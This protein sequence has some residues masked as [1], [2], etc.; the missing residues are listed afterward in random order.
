M[1]S[2]VQAVASG[3]V[4]VVNE[5]NYPWLVKGSYADYIG[6]TGGYVLPNGTLLLSLWGNSF[7]SANTTLNWLVLNRTGDMAWL[8]L[9]YHAS[10]C[11]VSRE[12]YAD[13]AKYN[14]TR[15]PCTKFEFGV[16]QTLEM[17]VVTSEVYNGSQPAGILNFWAPPLISSGTTSDGTAF[18]NGK[19]EVVV[20][21]V[22]GPY[23]TKSS[24]CSAASPCSTLGGPTGSQLTVNESGTAYTG[25]YSYYTLTPGNIGRGHNQTVG[26]FRVF[27]FSNSNSFSP[28]PTPSG[29]YNYDSGLALDFSEPEYPI[30]TWVCG[31]SGGNATNCEFTTYSTTLGTLFRSEGGFPLY[32]ASTNIPIRPSLTSTSQSSTQPSASTTSSGFSLTIWDVVGVAVAFVVVSVLAVF[33]RTRPRGSSRRR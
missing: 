8:R 27:P 16:T 15:K 11:D 33:L 29:T 19:S 21:N 17:D 1:F 3:S 32:L 7:P 18:V 2:S 4:T 23:T 26:W 13:A 6:G 25:P 20:S 31:D 30:Q 22:T 9:R 24:N 14:F 10:G 28:M 12:D 5:S